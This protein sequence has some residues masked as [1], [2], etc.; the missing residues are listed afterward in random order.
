VALCFRFRFSSPDIF[1]F[2]SSL[3]LAGGCKRR[4]PRVG[5]FLTPRRGGSTHGKRSEEGLVELFG[6]RWMMQEFAQLRRL[7]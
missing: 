5:I 7:W 4:I 1:G 3:S 2:R 6:E